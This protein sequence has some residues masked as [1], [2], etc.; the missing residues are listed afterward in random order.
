VN[1]N[2]IATIDDL[3]Q[4]VSIVTPPDTGMS[5]HIQ[6]E[7]S[8]YVDKH[9]LF[10]RA[11]RRR[12][13]H[14]PQRVLFRGHSSAAWTLAPQIDRLPYLTFRKYNTRTR[15]QQERDLLQSFARAARPHVTSL[16]PTSM[17][18]W[19]ALAQHHRLATRLLDWSTNP[20]VALYFAVA[21]ILDTSDAAVWVYSHVGAIA[22]VDT[23]PFESA[24]IVVFY[25]PYLT[26]R[27]SAQSGCFTVHPADSTW[28]T[29]PYGLRVPADSRSRIRRQLLSL[30]VNSSTLFPDLDGISS[31][32]NA[33][34]A[35]VAASDRTQT[36][37]GNA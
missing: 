22:D 21:D 34:F 30:G 8:G 5:R 29:I 26:S 7:S 6:W 19:L 35:H 23:D 36:P 37:A 14:V 25:P 13:E 11:M 9:E 12:A 18:E 3:S 31:F 4:F 20:L 1:D 32:V 27:I 24:S 33:R 15:V 10:A 17:W 28:E 2:W 16:P